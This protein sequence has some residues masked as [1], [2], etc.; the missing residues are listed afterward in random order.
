MPSKK[1]KTAPKKKSGRPTMADIEAQRVLA[2]IRRIYESERL[3]QAATARRLGME[4]SSLSDILQGHNK[5]SLDTAR[6]VAREEG[7]ALADYLE[8][9][10][11]D[12]FDPKYPSKVRAASAARRVLLDEEAIEMMRRED[13]GLRQDPGPLYWL[14]EVERFASLLRARRHQ[15]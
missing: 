12:D 2:G 9:Y 5:P 15:P 1:L 10:W 8:E 11:G 7:R 6:A 13:P 14:K 3:N 4:P